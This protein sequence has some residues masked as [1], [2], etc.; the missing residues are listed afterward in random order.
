MAEDRDLGLPGSAVPT[1]W[2]D[3]SALCGDVFRT[4]VPGDRAWRS[5]AL[6][7]IWGGKAGVSCIV[8]DDFRG[9][10]MSFVLYGYQ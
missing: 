3:L 7:C 2:S 5:G 4:F 8:K 10:I 6:G 1:V 9:V